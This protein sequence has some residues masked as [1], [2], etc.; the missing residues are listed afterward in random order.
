MIFRRSSGAP[1]PPAWELH[2][3]LHQVPEISKPTSLVFDLRSWR[4]RRCP[5]L[6]G[7]RL[8]AQRCAVAAR[9][10]NIC[11]SLRFQRNSGLRALN[12]AVTYDQTQ[13]FARS[14]AEFFAEQQPT[15]I[16]A[17]MAKSERHGK[18][19][20]DWSQNSDFK[21]TV[22]VYSLRAKLH[23]P[24]VS[25]PVTWDELQKAVH[26]RKPGALF[27]DPETTLKRLDSLG[28]L[29]EKVN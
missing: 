22:G 17:E 5:R 25:C 16:V 27:F 29:L 15:Q 10:R 8:L 21:T 26:K 12:S 13:P 9:A 11:E 18:V 28:D 2:P 14:L 20:V 6:C 23:R 4:R 7:R 1:M 24:F 19:L 3:F